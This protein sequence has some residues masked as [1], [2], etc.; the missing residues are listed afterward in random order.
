M[1][2]PKKNS[3]H[4]I[5]I[6]NVTA[7]GSGVGRIDGFTIFVE[8]A[9]PGDKLNIHIVKAKSR[10][11]FG[12]IIEILQPSPHRIESPCPIFSRCGGCQW[13]NCNYEAQL[14]FKKQIVI[15][16]LE[17]IGGVENPPVENVLGQLKIKCAC[18]R[19]SYRPISY[20]MR[21]SYQLKDNI[22]ALMHKDGEN[23]EILHHHSAPHHYRNKA[24]FPV[25]PSNNEDGFAIGMFAARS[26]RIVELEYCNI[27]H[28]AHVAVIKA[29]K[30]YMRRN[31]VTPYDEISHKGLMRFIM[32]RTSLA[33]GEIM[34]VLTINGKALPLEE[35][36]AEDLKEVGATAVIISRHTAKSN[37]VLGDHFRVIHGSGTITERIGHVSY[38]ISAPSFF[39]INPVQTKALYEIAVQ[40][41]DLKGKTVID[42]HVGAGGVSLFAAKYAKEI[43]GV[44][45]VQAAIDDGEKNAELNS[46]SNMKFIC[47][48]AEEVLPPVIKEI[49]PEVMFLDPPRKGCDKAL[50]DAIILAQVPRIVYISCDPATLARDVKVLIE[51]GY[52]LAAARP[53]D[54]FPH[55]GK[56][57]VS[58]LLVL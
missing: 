47:G 55:T 23:S 20:S 53:V 52:T 12:K 8:G 9:L 1:E 27:Q 28:P 33:T 57:E 25:V 26:H 7:T 3:Q 56:I 49:A 24:V 4:I 21:K 40:Q 38:Q 22:E 19:V 50:L 32:V 48:A 15:D 37:V 51:G 31:K 13:Q 43:I 46:I 29:V 39:Q 35:R 14:A 16:A 5:E 42:A 44:D 30:K 10:Y 11:G 2:T 34:V 58:C 36:L 54:M 18:A 45:I 17:R 41:A 6:E